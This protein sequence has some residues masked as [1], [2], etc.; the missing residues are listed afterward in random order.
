MINITEALNKRRIRKQLLDASL[1]L[2]VYEL[3]RNSVV[4]GVKSFFFSG[5]DNGKEIYSED[6]FKE[7][8]P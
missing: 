7:V 6:Y 4:D 5:I 8:L 2:L 1:F 3:L